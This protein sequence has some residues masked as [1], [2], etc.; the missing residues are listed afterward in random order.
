MELNDANPTWYT[1]SRSDGHG[2]ITRTGYSRTFRTL[3][4]VIAEGGYAGAEY[5]FHD[6]AGKHVL[7]VGCGGYGY[8]VR[9]L[10]ENRKYDAEWGRPTDKPSV[11]VVHAIGI[12]IKLDDEEKSMP[13]YFRQADAR[14]TPFSDGEFDTIFSTWSVFHYEKDETLLKEMLTEMKRILKQGGTMRFSPVNHAV[15]RKLI[16]EIGGLHETERSVQAHSYW[17]E[18][19]K[20]GG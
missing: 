15:L 19:E 20:T 12:D 2:G 17:I 16:G 18:I 4:Q 14:H 7:D 9:E 3:D 5:L 10:N 11:G 8:F 1:V 13:K 6:L